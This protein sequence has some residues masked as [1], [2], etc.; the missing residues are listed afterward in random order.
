MKQI[1][2]VRSKKCVDNSFKDTMCNSP[3]AHV[4]ALF[5]TLA[6][7]PQK[8]E[9]AG[10]RL[11]TEVAT[12]NTILFAFTRSSAVMHKRESGQ[13]IGSQST[14]EG[15]EEER[16]GVNLSGE[17]IRSAFGPHSA[18]KE[19]AAT[20]TSHSATHISALQTSLCLRLRH[21]HTHTSFLSHKY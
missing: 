6:L 11:Q 7:H 4:V 16:E 9:E 12:L 20:S 13:L 3:V 14:N 10:G 8:S 5:T 15:A 19:T 2:G 21:T 18:G 17:R 1:R